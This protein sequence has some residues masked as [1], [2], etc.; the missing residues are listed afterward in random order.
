MAE[1]FNPIGNAGMSLQTITPTVV[2]PLAALAENQDFSGRPIARQDMD[3][4]RPTPGFARTRDTASVFS[5]SL[6]YWLNAASGGTEFSP[7]LLS[8]SPDQIDYL[9]GQVTGGV[10]R[11]LLKTSQVIGSTVTGEEIAPYKVPLAGRFFGD[12]TSQSAVSNAF[13]ENLRTVFRHKAEMDGRRKAGE[14]VAEYMR[15]NPGSRLVT[16]ASQVDRDVDE[17]RRARRGTSGPEL[18]RIDAQ[19]RARMAAF[20]DRVRALEQ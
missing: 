3:P 11:E 4:M 5:K 9:I 15:E 10:G 1:S 2:D 8:P 12:A 16:L 18:A 17:L 14:S 6:S 19:M 7:G 20:N 13:Q